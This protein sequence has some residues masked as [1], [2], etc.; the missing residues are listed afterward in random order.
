M[1]WKILFLRLRRCFK[2]WSLFVSDFIYC[3]LIVYN[4]I[5]YRIWHR[6]ETW[7]DLHITVAWKKEKQYHQLFSFKK[8]F[9]MRKKCLFKIILDWHQIVFYDSN[10]VTKSFIL[11]SFRPDFLQLNV[12]LPPWQSEDSLKSLTTSKEL[13]RCHQIEYP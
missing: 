3:H 11:S 9:S 2:N 7:N 5:W 4:W 13:N 12:Y 10:K 1:H 6:Y 8:Y